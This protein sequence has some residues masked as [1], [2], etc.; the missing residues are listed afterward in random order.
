[1]KHKSKS[2]ILSGQIRA[3][4]ISTEEGFRKRLAIKEDVNSDTHIR[5]EIHKII[6]DDI[7]NGKNKEDIF[8]DLSNE[9]YSKYNSYFETWI[10]DKIKKMEKKKQIDER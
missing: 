6:S 4:R 8:K 7:A 1:M 3:D 2:A 5:I 10:D 9:K